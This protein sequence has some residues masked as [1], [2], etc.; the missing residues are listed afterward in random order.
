MS[1][2]TLR[3]ILSLMSLQLF[4]CRS[5]RRRA[6]CTISCCCQTV[7][8]KRQKTNKQKKQNEKTNK[9]KKNTPLP[10]CGVE[11]GQCAPLMATSDTISGE[12][13]IRASRHSE[14]TPPPVLRSSS[15]L[16]PRMK[17]GTLCRCSS[18]LFCLFHPT[19]TQKK[20]KKKRGRPSRQ[21]SDFV[22]PCN[23]DDAPCKTSVCR[24]RRDR[25]RTRAAREKTG[26]F[27]F[28]LQTTEKLFILMT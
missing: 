23:Q 3:L 22:Q 21:T 15:L 17:A 16:C 28:A 6:R 26:C 10:T 14:K 13:F 5:A 7:G 27:Y 4:K 8:P 20:N 25:T 1:L 12:H 9:I 2:G 24:R 11:P 18:L 19:G